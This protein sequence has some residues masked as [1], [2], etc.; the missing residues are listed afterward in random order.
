MKPQKSINREF[1]IMK[2]IRHLGIV[3]GVLALAACGGGSSDNSLGDGGSASLTI[4]ADR[5]T[6]TANPQNR[7]P[8]ADSPFSVQVNVRMTNP[9]GGVV[10][11][12]T[13]INLASENSSLGV[14][15]PV[16]A[17][18]QAGSSASATTS[19]GVARFHFTSGSESGTVQ[20]DASAQNPG[21]GS[22]LTASITMTVEPAAEDAARLSIEGAETMPANKQGVP[23]FLGSP[24]INELTVRYRDADGQA[25]QVADGEVA[26]A[27]SPVSRGAFSTLDDPE[28][29]ENDFEVLLGSGTANLTAGVSTIFVHSF[30]QPGPLA[31]DVLAIDAETGEAFS[32]EFVI[33]IIDGAADFLPAQMDFDVSPSPVYVTGSGGSTTKQGQLIV[34]DSG[35]NQVPDPEADGASWNNVILSLDA[36]EGSGARLTGTGADGSVSGTEINVQTV[37]GIAS[38]A[39]NAG[40]VPGSHRVTATVDRADN[41]VDVELIDPLTTETTIQ[42]GDGRLFALTLVS[43]TF[44][45]IVVNSSSL[46]IDTGLEPEFDPDTGV[47]LPPDPDGTYSLTVTALGTDQVG[48]PV[49]PGTVVNFGKIDSPLA[50]PPPRIF[51]FSGVDGNPEEGGTL[52]SVFDPPVGFTNDPNF[53][54]DDVEVGDTV[55]LFGKAVPGNREHEAVRFVESVIDESTLRVTE[56]FN[57]NDGSG[58]PVDDGFV[59]PWVI[60]RSQV[61]V[62]DNTVA[63]DDRGRGT[64]QLT[65][66][67]N[68]L[69]RS[70]VVWGQGVRGSNDPIKTVADVRSTAF[71]GVT[72]LRLTASPATIPGNATT[73][74]E[75]C[76]RDGLGAPIEGLFVRGSITD[77][78][79]TGSLDGQ[80]MSTLTQNATG[81][82]GCLIT[83]V[84]TDG[85]VPEGDGAVI[86]FQVGDTIPVEVNVNPPGSATL[87]V[88]PSQIIDSVLGTLTR[89][90]QLTLLS[91]DGTPVSGAQI[92]GEC[93]AA[94]GVLELTASPGA[95]NASGQTTAEVT[96]GL[97][98]CGTGFADG[99]FPRTG[100][101]TF[102]TDSDVPEGRLTVFGEDVRVPGEPTPDGCPPLE[103]TGDNRLIVNVQGSEPNRILSEPSGIDC[104]MFRTND[105]TNPFEEATDCVASFERSSIILQAP[106]GT[107]PTWV[108]DCV[109]VPGADLF[110]EIDFD[111]V[112]S[113]AVC[114]VQF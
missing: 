80:P 85:M 19:G 86:T 45:S 39:L 52:F 59:I 25:G 11:D 22:T 63:L 3:L 107:S 27:V 49:L 36:P 6:V 76:V 62:I 56:P 32:T 41:N 69:G 77:G 109:P 5:T 34:R 50:G 24:F 89:E 40:D 35:G 46:G 74:V 48:N 110:A 94:D 33:D 101:C 103:D 114:A 64:V 113:P 105:P 30:D 92:S 88:D 90:I 100:V 66:P 2:M 10:S 78:T 54:D 12:G 1:S 26:V 111:V 84:T 7:S 75:L 87:L 58:S 95:T 15:S 37:N 91:A 108:G 17:P 67:V 65:Y 102:T 72:P 60:G 21:G 73:S 13:T 55:A 9:T 57:L 14:V 8:G 51:V 106:T 97:A 28:T 98:G 16:D 23:I 99:D 96:Y 47:L 68:A 93:E 70:I 61:G 18:E 38:F 79:A 42:V 82:G 53:A 31:V 20:L 81:S 43:P 29:D 112:D 44:N 4:T 71:G 83:E 104:G